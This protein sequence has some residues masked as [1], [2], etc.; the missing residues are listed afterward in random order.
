[1]ASPFPSPADSSSCTFSHCFCRWLRECSPE[2]PPVV[3]GSEFAYIPDDAVD[4]PALSVLVGVVSKFDIDSSLRLHRFRVAQSGRVLGRSGDALEILVDGVDIKPKNTW[5]RIHAAAATRSPDGRSLSLCCFSRELDLLDLDKVEPPRVFELHMDLGGAANGIRTAL[6]PLPDLTLGPHTPTFPISAAGELWAPYLTDLLGPSRLVMQRLDKDAGRWV[7]VADLHLPHGRKGA[8]W[9]KDN[10]VFQGYAL[11]GHT[12]LLSLYPFNHFFTFD[13]STL[14]WASV[15]TTET[16]WRRYVPIQN[17]AV[18][19]ETDDTIYFLCAGS[20]YAYK[21]CQV[22]QHRHR[23]EPPIRVDHVCPFHRKGNGFL[24]HIGGRVMCFVWIGEKLRCNCDIKH[25]LITTFRVLK[26]DSEKFPAVF[27][28]NGIEVLHSTCRRMGMWPSKLDGSF[29]EFITLQVYEEEF[30]H[31]TAT[32]SDIKKGQKLSG[33]REVPATSIVVES[34]KMLACCRKLFIGTPFSYSVM[35]ER[36]AIR[37]CKSLYIVCQMGSSAAV[38]G[39][40]MFDGKLTCHEK[41]LTFCPMYYPLGCHYVSS[42]DTIF[43]V[44]SKGGH[45]YDLHLDTMG[46]RGIPKK[47]IGVDVCFACKVGNG[48]IAISDSF[49]T[50]YSMDYAQEWGCLETS[51]LPDDLKKEVN[52][53][54]YVVLSDYSFMVSDAESNQCFLFDLRDK[55]WRTVKPYALQD[56][57]KQLPNSWAGSTFLSERSVFVKGFIYTCSSG[58]LTAYE[59]IEE[60]DSYYLGEGIELQFSWCKSWEH[61]RMCLDHVGQDS[62]SGPIMFCVVQDDVG[63]PGFPEDHH[64]I[65]FTTVQVKTER[66]HNGKLKPKEIGHVDIAR[67]YIVSPIEF[68]SSIERD[69]PLVWTRSCFHSSTVSH[70]LQLL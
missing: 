54:G 15:I 12:I 30:T 40:R 39:I 16:E 9:S 53:S 19:V 28:P 14:T 62:R 24:T 17:R 69:E 46:S 66:M 3:S 51:D 11:V 50:Y 31:E 37:T 65:C 34:S 23:M 57:A 26:D 41:T 60:G 63:Q 6:S 43:A 35:L 49:Q 52:L 29:F 2:I 48:I 44:S 61:D 25:V 21:L 64:P 68:D 32:T 20:V 55:I 10:P 36:S 70:A 8:N 38:F 45:I 5:P 18:Y 56:R 58:G 13:C 22:D 1:M 59:L 4:S 7:E 47:P 42:H 27:V 33:P 67:S